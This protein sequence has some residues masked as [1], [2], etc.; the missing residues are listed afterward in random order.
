MNIYIMVLLITGAIAISLVPKAE[1][2]PYDQLY[3]RGREA[4][5]NDDYL[6]ATE[7]LFAYSYLAKDLLNR[8]TFDQ[9]NQSIKYSDKQIRYAIRVKQDLDRHGKI[10][11]VTVEASG[12]ADDPS[13]RTH[14]TH[15]YKP[16]L[17]HY[18]KKPNLPPSPP[19][20]VR[21]YLRPP[22]ALYR[23]P[24]DRLQPTQ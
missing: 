4:Y 13:Q 22:D 12:K 9:I 8:A 1:A 14:V 3:S 19:G 2:N 7:Y 6:T 5:N 15:A 20:R 11:E 16:P 18:Y 23:A 24:P 17:Q 21:G 10:T